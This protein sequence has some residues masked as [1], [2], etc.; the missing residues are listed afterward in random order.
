MVRAT[1]K[2]T[3]KASE[4]SLFL[5]YTFDDVFNGK[6]PILNLLLKYNFVVIMNLNLWEIDSNLI[7]TW[8]LI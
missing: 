8:F 4:V 2:L 7:L 5:K 1:Y 3:P 6:V